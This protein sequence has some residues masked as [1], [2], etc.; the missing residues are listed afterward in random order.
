MYSCTTLEKNGLHDDKFKVIYTA[1]YPDLAK[2]LL[3]KTLSNSSIYV[4]CFFLGK[5]R[6]QTGVIYSIN[7]VVDSINNLESE[8]TVI[9]K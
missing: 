9:K 7:L 8:N 6:N 5:R 1:C 3:H 2:H 4:F